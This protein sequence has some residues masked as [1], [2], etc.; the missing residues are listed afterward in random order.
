MTTDDSAV[1]L[2]LVDDLQEN[3]VALEALIRGPG[4]RIF[5]ARSG[6]EALSLMIEHP[7][8][9]AILD[10]QM[11]SM[12]G[13]ELAEL[14]RGTERTRTIPIVFVSAAGRELNYAFRGYESGAVDFLYKPLDA[15]AVKS[16]VRVF[17][18]LYRKSREL[19]RQLVELEAARAGQEQL[20]IQLQQT[21]GELQRSLTM[22][23]EFMSMVSHELRTP[24]GVMTLDAVMRQ[25][26]LD[27]G[28]LAYFGRERLQTMLARD[29]RQLRSM[30]RLI[31]DMLDISRIQHG[32]LSIRPRRT[33][34]GE[35][36]R[37][38][39]DDFSVH[40]GSVPLQVQAESGIAGDW[41]DSRIGQVLV[42]LLSNALRYGE[43]KPVQVEVRREADGMALLAVADQ[44]PGIAPE[45]QQR[46]F[47]QFERLPTAQSSPGMG[48]GLFISRYFVEAHGGSLTVKSQPGEGARFEV[49]L[50]MAVDAMP[51]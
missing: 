24:L 6:D 31:D 30:T 38:I 12:N 20:L 35:L 32:K 14:M 13:F 51:A 44:G 5:T 42:N 11:P 22:R 1:N 36:A 29:A 23:D 49:R 48:L 21:Q 15:H 2:L 19:R 27:R 46:V 10:V 17:T 3:L 26:R 7:F 39:V 33:D 8:A 47:E 40:Y 4:R 9:L 43:G 34:L 18:E 41:D 16:K 25:E 50:P 45:D 37:H 28:D